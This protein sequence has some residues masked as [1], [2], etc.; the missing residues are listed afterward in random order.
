M[1][2]FPTTRLLLFG[3]LLTAVLGGSAYYGARSRPAPLP[4]PPAKADAIVGPNKIQVM[5]P[6][7]Y[8]SA[9]PAD[10]LDWTIPPS[11]AVWPDPDDNS[12]KLLA[13]QA[14]TFTLGLTLR[15]VRE[16]KY[17]EARCEL[18]I[19]VLAG[20]QPGPQ[21]LPGP[22]PQPTPQPQPPP[23]PTPQPQPQPAPTPG[24]QP[25]PLDKYGFTV[26]SRDAVGQ[27][28]QSPTRT[29]EAAKLAQHFEAVAG[30][31]ADG[32][33]TG[34][35]PIAEATLSGLDGALGPSRAAWDPWLNAFKSRTRATFRLDSPPAEIRLGWLETAAGL[36]LAK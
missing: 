9:N 6:V 20:P 13:F 21:P 7:E 16:G 11:F 34:V 4:T 19:E 33:L 23:T 10:V 17:H 27:L 14:G 3:L 28:V 5:Q 2:T 12:L 35:V 30:A 8:R 22:S 32:R 24:P 36:R 1:E 25:A 31:I 26:W 15:G 29:N 18:P